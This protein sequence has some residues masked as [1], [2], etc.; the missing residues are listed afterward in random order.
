LPIRSD[1]VQGTSVE[2]PR[3][4]ITAGNLPATGSASL[5]KS[6]PTTWKRHS[7]ASPRPQPCAALPR[8]P[9]EVI[10]GHLGQM[11][12]HIVGTRENWNGL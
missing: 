1:Q 9:G 3:R 8:G 7:S 12:G 6:C 2:T 10:S 11:I 5:S 4:M